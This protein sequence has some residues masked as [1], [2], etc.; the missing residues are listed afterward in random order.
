MMTSMIP[1]VGANLII[2][3]LMNAT[4][5]Q[6]IP[7][8]F[9]VGVTTDD[10]AWTDTELNDSVVIL[11]G[12]YTKTLESVVIDTTNANI[13]FNAWLSVTEAN[14][15]LLTGFAIVNTDASE[16][17]VTKSKFTGVSKANNQLFK[18]SLVMK[19]RDS[20]LIV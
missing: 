6:S 13:T 14:G 19:I 20:S 1:K 16:K 18:F 8:R 3:R 17:L 7:S 11:A 4:P 10:C 15:N 9:R 5:T 12:A 2:D